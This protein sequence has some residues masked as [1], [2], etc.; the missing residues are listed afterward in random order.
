MRLPSASHYSGWLMSMYSLWIGPIASI[1][2]FI[3]WA[4]PYSRGRKKQL[5]LQ[6]AHMRLNLVIWMTKYSSVILKPKQVFKTHE[7][8]QKCQKFPF[9]IG[10]LGSESLDTDSSSYF[11]INRRGTKHSWGLKNNWTVVQTLWVSQIQSSL[12]L[13]ILR[14]EFKGNVIFVYL[15]VFVGGVLFLTHPNAIWP[16]MLIFEKS[17]EPFYNL[18][19]AL[20]F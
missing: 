19:S 16:R 4:G 7:I 12:T 5:T 6:R 17:F 3:V 8:A 20:F 9:W 15:H 1:Y 10:F 18:S 13:F 2:G 14:R 11:L